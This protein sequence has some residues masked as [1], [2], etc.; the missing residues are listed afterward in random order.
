MRL[1]PF[2]R[3]L[4][5]LLIKVGTEFALR[6]ILRSALMRFKVIFLTLLGGFRALSLICILFFLLTLFGPLVG[7]RGKQIVLLI[8]LL[9]GLLGTAHEGFFIV[10]LVQIVL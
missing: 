6:V 4:N 10:N 7:L 1:K 5:L 2:C 9:G 3:L 8:I